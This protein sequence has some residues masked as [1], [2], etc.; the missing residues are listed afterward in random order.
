VSEIRV[1]LPGQED[2]GARLVTAEAGGISFTSVYVPNGR[3]IDH[4]DFRGKLAWLDALADHWKENHPADLPA[5]LAGD[6]NV[7][8]APVD[9]WNEKKLGGS[10]FHTDEERA[11]IRRFHELGLRDAFRT[12]HPDEPGFSWWDYRMGAF[13]RGWGLRI[14]LL[15]STPPIGIREASVDRD[16]RKKKE[17]LT[18]S[19]H[20]PVVLELDA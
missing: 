1:G 17:G 8:A 15:F 9:S 5:I 3:R 7:C 18:A 11:R 12:V 19:D 4:E 16:Y 10:I 20:A 14:D 6:F 13:H 2:F